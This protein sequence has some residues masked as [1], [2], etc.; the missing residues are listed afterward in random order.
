MSLL[1]QGNGQ[2]LPTFNVDT[3]LLTVSGHS[4]G[5]FFSTQFHVA[6]SSLIKGAVVWGGMPDLCF[7]EHGFRCI[8]NPSVTNVS[9]LVEKTKDLSQNGSIDSVSNLSETR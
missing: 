4:S 3:D 2:E 1:G 7:T 6:Y 9:V 8:E 5:G